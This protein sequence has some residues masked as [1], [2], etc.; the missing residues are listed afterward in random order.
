MP[1][2]VKENIEHFT[3]RT[4]L[5]PHLIK[6]FDQS[7]ERMFILTGKPG[8][9]KSMIAAWLAGAGPLPADIEAQTQL[10]QIHSW[11]KGTHFCV[12][13]SGNTDPKLLAQNIAEQLTRNVI[14]FGDALKDTLTD[15]LVQ[16][17]SIQEIGIVE[18]GGSVTGVTIKRL[19][20]GAL[21]EELSFNRF[22]R[23]PIKKL[24]DSGYEEPMLLIIDALDEAT[25]Y[26]GK[27]NIVQLLAKINDLPSQVRILVTTRPDPRI[28]KYYHE[29]KP[30]DLI[31]DMSVDD[32][33]FYA[34]ERL[35]GL[36]N[37]K[38]N[39][40]TGRITETAEGNFL[41]AYLILNDLL[42]HLP[43]IPDLAIMPFPKG[44]SGLYHDF[45]NRE[46]GAD[47]DRWYEEFKPLFGLIMVAQGEGL[48]RAQIE[49]ITGKD[50]E[51]TLRVCKQYIDGN[52]PEGPFRP[53]HKSFADFL[54]EDK[55]NKD[56]RINAV[57]CHRRIA[58]FYVGREES[59]DDVDFNQI[60]D[61]G[62]AHLTSHLILAGW[63]EKLHS[64]LG[65]EQQIDGRYENVWYNLKKA[66]GDTGG[67]LND[68]NRAWE[69]AEEEYANGKSPISI[70]LQYR[71]SL[72]IASVNSF[73][74]NILSDLLV[75][76][77]GKSIWPS[78]KGLAYARAVPASKRIMVAL[79][80]I[81]SK[82]SESGKEGAFKEALEAA[83][84]IR[85]DHDREKALAGIAP[86]LSESMMKEALEAARQIRDGYCRAKAL[87]GIAPYLSESMMKEALEAA[88]QIHIEDYRANVLAGIAC[89]LPE[90]QKDEVIKEAIEVARQIRNDHDRANVLAGI[91]L[92]LPESQ[93]DEI[94]KEVLEAARQIR[95]DYSRANVLAGIALHLPESMMKEALETAKQIRN[96][97]DRANALVGIAFHLPISQK[98]E[99]IKEALEAARQI[100]NDYDLANALARIAFHLP[101]SQKGEVIK[102]AIETARQIRNDHDRA[103][104]LAGIA[105]HLPESQKDEVMK[106]AL[107][108][109]RQ[110][111]IEYDRAKALAGI[112]P[113]LP[114]SQK[115]EALEAARQIRDGYYR[116]NA[117][118]GIA[119][120]MNILSLDLLY[121]IWVEIL[122][123]YSRT[124]RYLLGNLRELIPFIYKLG[125]EKALNE[126]FYAI[127]D[128]TRWWS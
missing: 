73:S 25:T 26:T 127:E 123:E 3:G 111:H 103:N 100:R 121:P 128:V 33:L 116:A 7:D 50:V 55:D 112:A 101:E 29:V 110:I 84:Q 114:E 6:W 27:T 63:G 99:V 97:H 79:I 48:S 105:F 10:K 72:M 58:T 53:F 124:R 17:E 83:R 108:A 91:A 59:W 88:R 2:L 120:Y 77:V 49:N 13:D 117:L 70:G 126:T 69:L 42:P 81:A 1:G 98:D 28:L 54:L 96:D 89:H 115:D 68:V 95:N 39:M 82:L 46:L 92:H 86:Y 14:G 44:L 34:H 21:S 31:E 43:D 61:Y 56:Y 5:L 113:H 37:E 41:Y 18:A 24:Y 32:I 76:I 45:L 122:H 87:A 78:N 104:V 40:L 106:E 47:E 51:R 93:K 109:A 90:S 80:K 52:L 75:A 8:T 65:L 4:W 16:I 15:G 71:Y 35:V 94:M 23:E 102:E 125:E 64:L 107:E 11:V 20:L 118:A 74:A 119:S 36:D 66:R 19:D 9:G 60:D 30:F 57:E 38:R 12:A 85:D 62:L 67:Y 22:L